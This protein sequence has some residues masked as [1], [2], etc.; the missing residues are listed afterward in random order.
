M[1]VND[2]VCACLRRVCVCVCVCLFGWLFVCMCVC[3]TA[4]FRSSM[5]AV[6]L[7]SEPKRLCKRCVLDSLAEVVCRS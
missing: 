2:S 6:G 4:H 1:C 5:L 7:V 3:G